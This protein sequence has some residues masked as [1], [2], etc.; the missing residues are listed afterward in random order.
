MANYETNTGSVVEWTIPLS[1]AALTLLVV[2]RGPSG[3]SLKA[4]K[5]PAAWT[6]SIVTFWGSFDGQNYYR[7]KDS[8][9]GGLATLSFTA[10][11]TIEVFQ[12]ADFNELS[13]IPFLGIELGTQQAGTRIVETLWVPRSL[14]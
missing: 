4:I 12:R 7:L 9:G 3:T 5:V 11:D 2:P 13:S 8:A 14:G 1:H 6:A 10:V